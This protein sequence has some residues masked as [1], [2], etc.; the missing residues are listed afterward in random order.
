M[1]ANVIRLFEHIKLLQRGVELYQKEKSSSAEQLPNGINGENVRIGLLGA[2]SAGKTTLIRRLLSESAGKISSRPETAC[3]VVHRFSKSEN[4]TFRFRSKVRIDDETT[5]REFTQFLKTYKLNEYYDKN[6]VHDWTLKKDVVEESREYSREDI[7]SFFEQVNKFGEVFYKIVWNHKQRRNDYNLTDLVDIYD[8][9]G[10]GGRDEHDKEVADVFKHEKFDVLIYLIDTS[11]GIPSKD[12]LDYLAEVQKYLETNE[13][14]SFYWAYE[15]PSPE[16]MN[17]GE[18]RER[19]D[20]ALV[21]G[22]VAIGEFAKGLLDFTGPD[23]GDDEELRSD[24]MVNILKPYFVV[25]GKTY[26]D[27]AYEKAQEERR[28]EVDFFDVFMQDDTW[29]I[30]KGILERIELKEKA[31]KENGP[32]LTENEVRS[33]IV[34]SLIGPYQE[35]KGGVQK[36]ELEIGIE[37]GVVS[38]YSGPFFKVLRRLLKKGRTG[39]TAETCTCP[40]EKGADDRHLAMDAIRMRIDRA[41]EKIVNAIFNFDGTLSLTKMPSFKREVYARDEEIRMIGYDT[42]MYWMLKNP[43]GV[44]GFIKKPMADSLREN[45]DHELTAINEFDVEDD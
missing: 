21:S 39:H 15:K 45:I 5:G 37:T 30:I 27:A 40:S 28:G 44:V 2:T 26:L 36:S 13:K 29:P 33:F 32:G 14:T 16:K 18:M 8:L 31:K 1:D 12:E 20:E 23:D 24:F 6:S 34:E 43:E 19:I 10:F 41:V 7:F 11:C 4:L 22:G 35:L 9:P 25:V 38:K 3:L 17:L 42:Q